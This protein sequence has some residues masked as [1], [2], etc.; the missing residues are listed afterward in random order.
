MKDNLRAIFGVLMLIT[1]PGLLLSQ[2]SKRFVL[3]GTLEGLNNQTVYLSAIDNSGQR[4]VDSVEATNGTF[5]FENETPGTLMHSLRMGRTFFLLPISAGDQIT[6][7][8][9]LSESN[10]IEVSGSSEWHIW[11]KWNQ[12]WASITAVAGKLY[13]VA[14]SLHKTGGDR[15][16]V[17]QGFKELDERLFQTVKQFAVD[18][19]SSE[20][21]PFIIISR[22]VDYPNPENL[23]RTQA[24]LNEASMN[25]YYGKY[26]TETMAIASKTAIGKHPSFSV[27]DTDG[28]MVSLADFK[29][30]Y[31]FVDFW[32]SWCGPCRKENPHLVSAY[33]TYKDSGFEIIGISLD[34]KK[35]N[36]LKAI[37]DDQL[38]WIQLSDLKAWKSELVLEYGIKSIPMNFLVDREG[39]IIAKDLRGDALAETLSQIFE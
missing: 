26:I 35:D 12:E 5:R 24:L 20:I 17:D 16:A 15:S 21:V 18:Y 4:S 1:L 9:K 34:D 22:Y 19:P 30:K 27:P 36:W 38:E 39:K 32:A 10:R 8:G 37:K 25:S 3:E 2:E 14:D 29:G 6:L 7:S 11:S 33:N 13:R 31:V 28:D 23:Q